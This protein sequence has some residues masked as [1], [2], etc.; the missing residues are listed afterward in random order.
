[1]FVDLDHFKSVND[2]F[3]HDVGDTVLREL[4]AYLR[5][6]IR[7]ADI[8]GRYG[9]EEF[10][11]CLAGCDMDVAPKV[12]ERH[13]EQIA[14]IAFPRENHPERITASIGLAVFDPDAPDPSM[15][16]LLKRADAAV[17]EAKHAGRNRVVVAPQLVRLATERRSDALAHAVSLAPIALAAPARKPTAAEALEAALVE[18]INAGHGTLPV[19]PAVAM[20]ALRLARR[21]NADI[22]SLSKLCAE[23]PFI[24][25][26]LL[27][28]GNSALFYRGARTASLRDAI[29]RVGLD[30]TRDILASIAYWSALPKYHDLLERCSERAILAA[31]CAQ[32]ACHELGLPYEPAYLC[33]LLHDLGEARVLR[34]LSGLPT[35]PGGNRVIVALVQR[36]H[37]QAGATLAE[38]WHLHPD[39]VQA[40]TLHHDEAQAES[41]PVR[42]AMIADAFVHLAAQPSNGKLDP[43]TAKTCERL[44]ITPAVRARVLRAL[45][46]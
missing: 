23:D 1:M 21:A 13:R 18:A 33:G 20:A 29:V 34:I 31:R 43:A 42:V 36:Y 24:A 9:G 4:G 3:G 8:A 32:A 17:Y 45:A 44:G 12:A 11:I 16:A 41:L 37:T 14:R 22:T 25:A 15:A 26:R 46:E 30:G 39:I 7:G 35:P 38:K 28:V 27:A 6:S 40:C 10:V 5:R 2:R 19:I